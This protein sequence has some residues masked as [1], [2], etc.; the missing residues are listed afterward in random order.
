MT[1][2][3]IF[4]DSEKVNLGLGKSPSHSA[5]NSMVVIDDSDYKSTRKSNVNFSTNYLSL[6]EELKL[7]WYKN[8][9]V[10]SRNIKSLIFVFISPF[11]FLTILQLMQNL[12]DDYT[13]TLTHRNYNSTEIDAVDLKCTSNQHSKYNPDCISIGISVIVTFF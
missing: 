3:E 8:T 10:Y 11:V 9:L 2:S 6:K 1:E 7:M 5:K 4:I 13:S 12:S